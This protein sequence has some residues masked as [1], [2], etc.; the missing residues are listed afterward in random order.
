MLQS[1][2]RGKRHRKGRE[3]GL[4]TGPE[5]KGGGGNNDDDDEGDDEGP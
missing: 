4:V 5:R 2:W 1:D 3:E